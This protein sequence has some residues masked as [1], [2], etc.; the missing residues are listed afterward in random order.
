MSSEEAR[1]TMSDEMDDSSSD[2]DTEDNDAKE[3]IDS[4]TK[5]V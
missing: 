2:S 3:K 4:I 5:S 1:D